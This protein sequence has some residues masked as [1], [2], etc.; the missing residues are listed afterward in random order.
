MP[1]FD[2]LAFDIRFA[3]THKSGGEAEK[4]IRSLPDDAIEFLC[5]RIADYLRLSNWQKGPPVPPGRSP[6]MR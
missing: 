3:L 5:K 6:P 2:D 1:D 4:L